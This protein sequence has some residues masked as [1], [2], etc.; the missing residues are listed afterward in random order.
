MHTA[1]FRIASSRS[2]VLASK[3]AKT[4]Q[5]TW[6]LRRHLHMR[7]ALPYN[8]EGGLGDFMSTQTLQM[9]AVEYQQ[10]L[11]DRL[12][13]E[14]RDV[15]DKRKTVAQLVLDAARSQDRAVMFTYASHALNNSFFLHSLVRPILPLCTP[16]D[17]VPPSAPHPTTQAKNTSMQA[18]SGL[19][20]KNN[21]AALILCVPS[22][23]LP[24]TA[25]QD[26]ATSGSSPTLKGAWRS[27]PRLRPAPSSSARARAPSSPSRH[28]CLGEDSLAHP[29]SSLA[30][31]STSETRHAATASSPLSGVSHVPLQ[32]DPS[33]PARTFHT[34]VL[35][36]DNYKT[37]T[38]SFYDPAA[39][40]LSSLGP[41]DSRDL[42]T[43]GEYIYPLF[44]ISVHEH[45][46]LLDHGIWGKERYLKEFWT[47]VDWSQVV[48]RFETFTTTTI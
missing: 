11:L 1:A 2:A 39:P 41:Q 23:L 36:A 37:R 4:C 22:S 25:W 7:K 24:S 46:W 32:L 8:I 43:L 19:K 9:V 29:S 5:T 34:S 47:V 12:N 26:R 20:S 6:T 31:A 28:L 40:P 30:N 17:A 13:Q 44:C 45:C 33:S 38:R 21:S 10:G 18:S 48:K 3:S 27:C 16:T 14:C 42:T 15:E 35:S